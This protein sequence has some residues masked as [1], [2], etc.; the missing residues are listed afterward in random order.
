[1]AV[2]EGEI[3]PSLFPPTIPGAVRL[4]SDYEEHSDQMDEMAAPNA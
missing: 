1:M 4:P 2:E 3:A